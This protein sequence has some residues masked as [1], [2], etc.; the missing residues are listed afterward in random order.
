MELIV[1]NNFKN[2]YN[3]YYGKL[4]TEMVLESI[5]NVFV[6]NDPEVIVDTVNLVKT[7][8][9]C[10]F[11]YTRCYEEVIKKIL[12][13]FP[14]NEDIDKFIM[15][16]TLKV[17]VASG[18]TNI[19]ELL[20]SP[21]DIY[22]EVTSK[23]FRVT[24]RKVTD[25][26]IK[27][28][29]QAADKF[30]NE[31]YSVTDPPVNDWDEYFYMMCKNAARNSKCL[32]RRIGAVLVADKSIISTGYNG[33]PRGVPRCDMRWRLDNDFFKAYGDRVEGKQ[34]EGICPRYNIGFKSGEGLSVC[35]AGHAERNALINAAR[36][37][38]RTKGTILYMSCGIPCTPCLIEIINAG[39]KEIVVMS[40]QT[41]DETSMYLLNQSD[42]GIRLFDFIK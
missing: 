18:A 24:P 16:V 22:R 33:P 32:S 30:T 35:P 17:M 3:L 40:L 11:T 2:T 42:L 12:S 20:K 39:V 9:A 13:R 15:S 14:V 10:G 37:G 38:I 7:S 6:H 31:S 19:E 36:Y 29:K 41:Y 27:S 5:N 23:H 34:L 26:M 8:I 1:D 4:K 28:V 25:E 21:R